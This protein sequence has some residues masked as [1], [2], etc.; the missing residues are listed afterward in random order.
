MGNVLPLQVEF[1]LAEII[2]DKRFVDRLGLVARRL[3]WQ[4]I[5]GRLMTVGFEF[6]F[7][8]ALLHHFSG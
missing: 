3:S 2:F 1:Q 8:K 5:V 7:R 6:L 4:K